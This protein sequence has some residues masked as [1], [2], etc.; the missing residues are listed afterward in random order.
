[1]SEIEASIVNPAPYMKLNMG[2]S[3]RAFW[4]V[5][6]IVHNIAKRYYDDEIECESEFLLLV[7]DYDGD[8]SN[9]IVY[10]S[11]IGCKIIKDILNEYNQ[12]EIYHSDMELHL[13]CV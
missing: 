8:L 9:I 12:T 6:E 11:D 1:M 4:G 2:C 7:K 5:Y 3:Y 13:T 10:S